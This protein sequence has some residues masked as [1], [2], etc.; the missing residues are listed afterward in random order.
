MH[1]RIVAV[2]VSAVLVSI[3]PFTTAGADSTQRVE[4]GFTEDAARFRSTGSTGEPPGD[5]TCHDGA[6][7]GGEFC[8]RDAVLNTVEKLFDALARVS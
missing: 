1:A 8:G 4:F 2:V 3:I 7:D 6:W 5:S